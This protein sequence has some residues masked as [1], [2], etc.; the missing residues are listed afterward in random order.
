MIHYLGRRFL[1]TEPIGY[2]DQ[3]NLYAYVG[4]DPINSVDPTGLTGNDVTD[5]LLE[6]ADTTGRT[7]SDAADIAIDSLVF[8]FTVTGDALGTTKDVA[9]NSISDVFDNS[10]QTPMQ[11]G[12]EAE[13]RVL[14]DLGLDRNTSKVSTSE[15]SSIPDARNARV[16]VEI[17][18]CAVVS[19]TRQMRI[20]TESAR[21]SGRQFVLITG[22]DSKVRPTLEE[23]LDQI[24]RRNDLGP[25]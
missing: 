1:Q 18:D 17:K 25:Q 3:Y 21:A 24:V 20:Q 12:L 6:L 23:N 2:E 16:C 19:N 9:V 10:K 15:G 8:G 14:K 5:R 4:N 7:L 11:R 13:A 22:T